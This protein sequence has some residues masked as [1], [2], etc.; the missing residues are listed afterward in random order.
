AKA[1][2]WARTYADWRKLLEQKDIDAVLV[3]T[4]D[5]R[6]AAA[7]IAA[8]QLGKHVYTEKPLTHNVH[9]AQAV[10]RAA[11]KAKVATQMG[12]QI[13]AGDNYRRRGETVRSGALGPQK[14]VNVRVAGGAPDGNMPLNAEP[15]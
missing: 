3:A 5:H 7:T 4:P 2:P 9:E 14:R 11:A 6:H 1:E 15:G 12:T 10:M 13:H 8:L